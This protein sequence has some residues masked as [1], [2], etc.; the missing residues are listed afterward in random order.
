MFFVFLI[1]LTI[2]QDIIEVRRVE[3]VEVVAERVVNKPLEGR[4]GPSQPEQYNQ[5]FK[6]SKADK[7]RSQLFVFFFYPY[8]IKRRNDVDL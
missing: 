7:E 8:V 4:R 3:L 5:G 1:G 6:Q 2:N